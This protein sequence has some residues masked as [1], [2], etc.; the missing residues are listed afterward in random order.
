MLLCEG[1]LVLLY[2]SILLCME[3]K[4]ITEIEIIIKYVIFTMCIRKFSSLSGA[5]L[6]SD[7]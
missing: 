4:N 6:L 7:I 3:H 2:R 1:N 5:H